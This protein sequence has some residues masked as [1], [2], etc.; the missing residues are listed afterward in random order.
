MFSYHIALLLPVIRY[1]DIVQSQYNSICPKCYLSQQQLLLLLSSQLPLQ[2]SFAT[3]TRPKLF[4]VAAPTHVICSSTISCLCSREL[5]QQGRF[6]GLYLSSNI[7]VPA[8]AFHLL[9]YHLYS[10]S[11]KA[12]SGSRMKGKTEQ[13]QTFTGGKMNYPTISVHSLR[14]GKAQCKQKAWWRNAVFTEIH[15]FL[16]FCEGAVAWRMKCHCRVKTARLSHDLTKHST[17]TWIF[18]EPQPCMNP[19]LSGE[20]KGTNEVFVVRQS[21]LK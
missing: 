20:R 13:L 21:P 16:C 10:G 1:C 9:L 2:T 19:K 6:Y 3:L 5:C 4:P 11:P 7:L 8:V 18:L 14:Y 17:W 12:T 15:I